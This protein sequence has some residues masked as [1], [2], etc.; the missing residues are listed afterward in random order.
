MKNAKGVFWLA[1][2]VL[3]L[4]EAGCMVLEHGHSAAHIIMML[5]LFQ[6][7]IGVGVLVHHIT[8]PHKFW[9]RFLFGTVDNDEVK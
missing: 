2:I 6:V 5:I 8:M 9:M 4:I 3:I 1:I 7:A